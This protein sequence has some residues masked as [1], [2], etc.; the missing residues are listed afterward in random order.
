MLIIF[1]ICIIIRKYTKRNHQICLKCHINRHIQ[2]YLFSR[3][4]LTMKNISE[5][6]R[7][8]VTK[9]LIRKAFLEL[10]Q[11][12]P[13]QSISIKEL[14]GEAGINRGTFYAHYQDIYA[15]LEHIEAD[16][17][18]DF[19]EALTPIYQTADSEHFLVDICTGIF[20]CL[21]D[22]SDL[23]VVMLGDY[24]DQ[25]FVDRLLSIG[26]ESCLKAYSQYFQNAN[27]RQI[28]YFYAFVSAGCIGLVRQWLQ[29]GMSASANELARM[30]EDII[31]YG[32]GSLERSKQGQEA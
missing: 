13:I 20:Q 6:H 16:M 17:T 18:E 30:A 27:Q 1:F 4:V 7:T 12:K 3:S 31:L 23:C 15:L 19:N 21:K 11:E 29:D 22:N 8:R 14:C 28:E 2:P 26:K 32:I 24:S 5:D 9:M 25:S 10:L